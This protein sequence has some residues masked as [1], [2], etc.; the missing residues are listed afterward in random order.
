MSLTIELTGFES[1]VN[2]REGVARTYEWYL[3]NIFEGKGTTA[4]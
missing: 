2:L 3:K 1:K 4:Q